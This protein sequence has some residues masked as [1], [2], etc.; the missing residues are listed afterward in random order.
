ML[1]MES[2]PLTRRKKGTGQAQKTVMRSDFLGM[3]M[4]KKAVKILHTL[5]M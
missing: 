4:K 2:N 1:I 3:G 5:Y